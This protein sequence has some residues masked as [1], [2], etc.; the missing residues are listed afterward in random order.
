MF[1]IGVK[2]DYHQNV[3]YIHSRL[4]NYYIDTSMDIVIGTNSYI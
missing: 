4:N 1:E 3:K 2:F